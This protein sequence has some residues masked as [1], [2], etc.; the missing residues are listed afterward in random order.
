MTSLI[1]ILSNKTNLP[2]VIIQLILLFLMWLITS[3]MLDDFK[4]ITVIYLMLTPIITLL[5]G[6]FVGKSWFKRP[7]D[8]LNKKV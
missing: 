3:I 4:F 2:P 8:N 5:S 1:Y 7:N 6:L